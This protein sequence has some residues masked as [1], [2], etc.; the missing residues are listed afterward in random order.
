MAPN[1]YVPYVLQNKMNLLGY[2]RDPSLFY[3]FTRLEKS[4]KKHLN[5][6]YYTKWNIFMFLTGAIFM[7]R[8]TSCL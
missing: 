8:R 5:F 3:A 2:Y 1:S 7:A 4:L 6:I